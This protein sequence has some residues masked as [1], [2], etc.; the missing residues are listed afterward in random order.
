MYCRSIFS[1]GN[2]NTILA[3]TCRDNEYACAC[4]EHTSTACAHVEVIYAF[5]HS[6]LYH[7]DKGGGGGGGGGGG[8]RGN[9]PRCPHASY[10]TGPDGLLPRL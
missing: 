7:Y 1:V 3:V 6:N 9:Y 10:A 2:F 8:E 4:F 5:I